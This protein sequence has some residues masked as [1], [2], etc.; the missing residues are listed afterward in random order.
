[1]T[2]GKQICKTLKEIRHQ[3]AQ[4]NDI[5]FI[6]SPCTFEGDCTGTCPRCEAELQYIEQQLNLRRA[7]GKVIT[8]LGISTCI[9]P[10]NATPQTA[11][12]FSSNSHTE[13]TQAHHILIKGKVKDSRKKPVAG[14]NIV[15]KGTSNG[16]LSNKKGEFSLS[17]SG[18]NPIVIQY[19]GFITKEIPASS[20]KDSTFF[21]ITLQNDNQLMGEISVSQP[22]SVVNDKEQL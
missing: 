17:V 19:I 3:I 13:V 9:L 11:S 8:L 21:P 6:T 12:S 15:E 5:D 10:M 16:T 22:D 14:A 18:L 1:M 20:L 4:A 7:A 2:H